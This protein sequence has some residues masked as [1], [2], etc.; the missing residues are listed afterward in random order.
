MSVT[1]SASFAA[2][3]GTLGAGWRP[4]QK[5]SIANS[6]AGGFTS[7]WRAVGAP[8]QGAIPTT[9]ATCTSA[10]TGAF[11][12]NNPTAPSVTYLGKVEANMATA[13]TLI[14]CDRIAA[15][16]GLS[17]TTTTA[18]TV[19]GV[20]PANRGLASDGSDAE[21][22]LEWYTDTGASAVTATITYTDQTD[23]SRTVTVALAA[24]MRAGRMLLITPNAGQNIKTITSVT[25]PTTG[26]AGN[27]GV[28]LLRR[29]ASAPVAVTNQVTVLDPINL[30]MPRVYDNSCVTMFVN[31][32]TTSTGV[33]MGSIA[34]G[35]A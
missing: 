26:T 14:I 21:W 24:T 35:Q 13:G 19:N 6:L 17:G 12:F 3:L 28:T 2:F 4:I 33:I 11:A 9:W 32:S 22:Y 18:Q 34:L 27:Y 23:T 15:M 29:L 8:D 20:I 10:T 1:D 30:G 7:L 25:C 31:T 5:A 16:G